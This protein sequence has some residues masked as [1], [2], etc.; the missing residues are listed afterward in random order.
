MLGQELCKA[1]LNF[2]VLETLP[3]QPHHHYA[4]PLQQ[5]LDSFLNALS[6]SAELI[7]A[8]RGGYGTIE[9]LAHLEQDKTLFENKTVIGYSDVTALHSFL[10]NLNLRSIHG[11][12]IATQGFIEADEHELASLLLC[13]HKQSQTLNLTAGCELEGRLIGGN[14]SVLSHLM[15]TP[16]QLQLQKGDILFLEDIHEAPYALARSLKQLSFSPNFKDCHVLWGHLTKCGDL[17]YA[18]LIKTLM[19]NYTNAYSY[20][21]QVGHERPN[22]SLILG[23]KV[24][25]THHQLIQQLD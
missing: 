9:W 2:E 1:K 21:L 16:W 7:W 8:A 15:G 6:G 22:F 3:P 24:K 23:S 17:D 18:S 19:E 11:P 13:I 14:L 10:N 25:L 12:M 4:G 5:R 20:G